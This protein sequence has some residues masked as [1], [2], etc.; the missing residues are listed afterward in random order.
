MQDHVLVLLW[1]RVVKRSDILSGGSY[2]ATHRTGH[3]GL[4][5]AFTGNGLLKEAQDLFWLWLQSRGASHLSLQDQELLLI[6]VERPVP[7]SSAVLVQ[8]SIW[9]MP[10]R[11]SCW[12]CACR[13]TWSPL[14]SCWSC[15]TP[16]Q[17]EITAILDHMQ[18]QTIQ[19]T[20]E[21]LL[22]AL[23]NKNVILV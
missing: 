6:C 8:Q 1:Q 21:C 17:L 7:Q 16:S 4:S 9:T 5:L 18:R 19:S 22:F 3:S 2:C 15:A 14:K 23:F 11:N 13:F 20:T 12:P 10:K